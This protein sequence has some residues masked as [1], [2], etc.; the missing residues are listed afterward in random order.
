[1]NP[2]PTLPADQN[3]GDVS[4]RREYFVEGTVARPKSFLLLLGLASAVVAVF[5]TGQWLLDVWYFLS[6]TG[7]ALKS[8]LLL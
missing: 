2:T 6:H 8:F 7:H 5:Q 4:E 1:M 3:G